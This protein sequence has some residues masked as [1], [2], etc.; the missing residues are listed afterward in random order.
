MLK[1]AQINTVVVQ[2]KEVDRV[3][4]KP[5]TSAMQDT[6]YLK[7]AMEGQ[8]HIIALFSAIRLT[9]MNQKSV[10]LHWVVVVLL[11]LR[12]GR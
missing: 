5:T 1:Q 4:F 8:A 3:G 2:Q 11:P 6:L 12:R 10:A 7:A 9:Q